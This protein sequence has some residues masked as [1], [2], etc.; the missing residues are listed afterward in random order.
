[1]RTTFKVEVVA[2]SDQQYVQYVFK[3][4]DELENSFLRYVTATKCPNW[5]GYSPNIG[6]V[7]YVQC[8]Y[9]EAGETYL[10]RA[11]NETSHYNYTN[12]YFLNFI[13]ETEQIT[14]KEFKF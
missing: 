6:D 12:C 10:N 1:M 13:K 2:I 8:E 7:G 3:N 9:V 4:L 11:S 14:N 5:E